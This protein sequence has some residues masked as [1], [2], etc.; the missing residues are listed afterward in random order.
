METPVATGIE[1]HLLNDGDVVSPVE[2]HIDT[3]TTRVAL[4]AVMPVFMGYAVLLAVQQKLRAHMGIT[5]NASSAAYA[6][7]AGASCI[8]FG[9]LVFRLLHNVIFGALRPRS[10]VLVSYGLM[11]TSMCIVLLCG[12]AL[13]ITSVTF[14]FFA[15]TFAGASIGTFEA[16]IISCVTPLGHATKKWAV[17]GMPLGYNGAAIAAFA[18]FSLTPVASSVHVQVGCFSTVAVANVA[19]ALLFH[20][21]IP[22]V[23]FAASDDSFATFRNNI[24][25]W[26]EWLP[27]MAHHVVAMIVNMFVVIVMSTVVLYVFNT[28]HVPVT[29]SGSTVSK[30]VF[31]LVFNA[32]AFAG[33][34]CSR[35]ITYV[36]TPTC[37]PLVMLLLTLCGCGLVAARCAAAAWAGMLLVMCAN[38]TI[39][40]MTTKH[41]DDRLPR[42]FNLAALSVWLFA[43]DCAS[44]LAANLTDLIT[45]HI[46]VI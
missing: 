36:R 15:Y 23:G 18:T 8:F 31:L 28:D 1:S 22:D 39:Y 45:V 26:R 44:T 12:Y 2:S 19:G 34:F 40:A 16:T 32:C 35:A 10:R 6:F 29:P 38:G 21:A 43:G 24:S 27:A 9:N 33:D 11:V 20:N 30:N 46:G 13:R 3:G 7:G 25:L 41:I 4:G 42:R 37:S 17:M 14:V 5:D